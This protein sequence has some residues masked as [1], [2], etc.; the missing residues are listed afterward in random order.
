MTDDDFKTERWKY[1]GRRPSNS[2]GLLGVW[3]DASGERLAYKAKHRSIGATYDVLV[4]RNGDDVRAR[5]DS[6]TFVAQANENDPVVRD[7]VMEDRTA[8]AA[9]EL[10]KLE[11]AAKREDGFGSMT[12]DELRNK[13]FNL[14]P[15][16]RTAFLAQILRYIG[17]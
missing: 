14:A 1:A 9:D 8:Y 4:A 15:M 6:A 3:I 13:M 11:A 2:G 16:R 10:R 7:W 17:A 12:L 5:I